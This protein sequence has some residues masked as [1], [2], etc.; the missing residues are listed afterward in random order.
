VHFIPLELPDQ[1][2]SM[3]YTQTNI[4]SVTPSLEAC[5]MQE[6]NRK[7]TRRDSNKAK[8]AAGF[9]VNTHA[10]N[11]NGTALANHRSSKIGDRKSRSVY[12]RGLPKKGGAGGKGTWGRLGDEIS[13][14]PCL[15]DHDPNY[16]S[17]EQ[18]EITYKTLKPVWTDD[19]VEETVTPILREYLDNADAVEAIVA[20]SGLNIEGKKHLVVVC[21]LTI[22][23][24]MKNE[25][26]ELASE[27]IKTFVTPKY[28]VSDVRTANWKEK[29]KRKYESSFMG[30]Q[31]VSDGLVSLAQA[32][33][34]LQLDTPDAAE[35]LGKFVA[36]AINDNATTNEVLN[37]INAL[38]SALADECV[39]EAK[40]CLTQAHKIKHIWGVVGANLPLDVLKSKM[41]ILLKEYLSSGDS[42]EAMRCVRDLDVP[43]FNHELVYETVVMAIED[44]TERAS[45]MLVHLL[46]RFSDTTVVTSDQI[47]EGFNR[48]YSEMPDI[49]I[50]VP[51]AY[52]YLERIVNKCYDLKVIDMKLKIQAP[53]RSRKR[54]VSE[55][56]GGR[57]KN[58]F[59][60]R[61]YDM[62]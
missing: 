30:Q 54:F 29:T 56:D 55:G 53:N 51:N 57:L 9:V 6:K 40:C 18:D 34:E 41:T 33:Q 19:E 28:V 48:V 43:H 44:S 52:F 31:N 36:R 14:S 62:V 27:L 42:E 23:M 11:G 2:K 17:E 24:E 38:N 61:F 25:Y 16:D 8:D 46:K 5:H 13:Q 20:M 21:L 12:G 7:R 15:D 22:A 26:R 47:R 32:L 1:D 59:E 3:D 49:S 35:V 58:Y 50:D 37:E 39:R 10:M 4:A 60:D 45:N